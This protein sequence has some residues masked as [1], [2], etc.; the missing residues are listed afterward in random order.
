MTP[1]ELN[2][3]LGN[4]DLFDLLA[5]FSFNL[6]PCALQQCTLPLAIAFNFQLDT[7]CIHPPKRLVYSIRVYI[8]ING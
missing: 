7:P 6:S 5:I 1:D 2:L 3:Q 8:Y 4:D